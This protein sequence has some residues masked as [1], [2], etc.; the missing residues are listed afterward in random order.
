[1]PRINTRYVSG[2]VDEVVYEA[3]DAAGLPE[4]VISGF[5]GEAQAWQWNVTPVGTRGVRT[6]SLRIIVPVPGRATVDVVASASGDRGGKRSRASLVG[7]TH[8]TG[9]AAM[10]RAWLSATLA[11]ARD[12]AQRL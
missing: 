7:R 10:D 4:L 1:M 5:D 8:T 11:A 6:V 2:P 3:A 12:A 9:P